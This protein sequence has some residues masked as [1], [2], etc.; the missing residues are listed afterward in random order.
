MKKNIASAIILLELNGYTVKPPQ[1]QETEYQKAVRTG[2]KPRI[3]PP[4]TM[5]MDDLDHFRAS[6]GFVT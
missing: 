2:I 5:T 1:P 6:R 4:I 3:W